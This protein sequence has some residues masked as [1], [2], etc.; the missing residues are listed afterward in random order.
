MIHLQIHP[1]VSTVTN[2]YNDCV[3]P[4]IIKPAMATYGA[5]HAGLTHQVNNLGGMSELF[6]ASL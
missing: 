1:Q 4:G 3:E 6:L 2:R 5:A